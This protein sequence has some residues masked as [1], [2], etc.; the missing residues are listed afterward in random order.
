M[1]GYGSGQWY[2]NN[3]KATVESQDKIDIRWLNKLGLLFQGFALDFSR[4][5]RGEKCGLIGLRV[6]TDRLVLISR[7]RQ[8]GGRH[9]RNRSV[10]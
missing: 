3:S 1:G 2:R 9:R 4:A 5:R 6:E 10:V 7:H 8:N